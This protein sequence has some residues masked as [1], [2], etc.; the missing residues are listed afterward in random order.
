[1][2]FIYST[3]SYCEISTSALFC[4]CKPDL[5]LGEACVCVGAHQQKPWSTPSCSITDEQGPKMGKN[6]QLQVV[7]VCKLILSSGWQQQTQQRHTTRGVT[8]YSAQKEMKVNCTNPISHT[9]TSRT[10]YKLCYNLVVW[11]VW[12]LFASLGF[13]LVTPLHEIVI[14]RDVL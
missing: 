6:G 9:Y 3:F 8:I 5:A 14:T 7:S 13:R 10:T 1:M 2:A 11:L 12:L 4:T